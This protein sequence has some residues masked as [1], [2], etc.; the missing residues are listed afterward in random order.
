MEYPKIN[1]IYKRTELDRTTVDRSTVPPR[2]LIMGDY[3]CP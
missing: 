3:S 2:S 1:S